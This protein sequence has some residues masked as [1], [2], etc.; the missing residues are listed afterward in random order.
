MYVATRELRIDAG[1]GRVKTVQP[2]E[3]VDV[4]GWSAR[5]IRAH[6]RRRNIQA[7][8]A[9]ESKPS[10]PKPAAKKKASSK[11]KATKTTKKAAKPAEA[12]ETTEEGSEAQANAL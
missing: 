2:G 6:L 3:S 1:D 7:A 8:E 4:S 11:K 9:K 5:V 10:E 12:K